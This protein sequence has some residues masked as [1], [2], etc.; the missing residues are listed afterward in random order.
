[1]KHYLPFIL[2][3][4]TVCFQCKKDDTLTDAEQTAALKNVTL[5]Y[6]S[7]NYVLGLPDGAPS[8][9]SFDQL[10]MEDS[11]KY[12]DP[13]N[14]SITYSSNFTADNSKNT[15]SD[16]KFEGMDLAVIMDTIKSGPI[17]SSVGSFEVKKMTKIPVAANST[18]NLKTHRKTGLYIFQQIVDGNDLATTFS[19]KLKYKIG[20]LQGSIP[21]PEIKQNIPTRASDNTRAFLSGLIQS[22]VFELKQ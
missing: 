19:P 8:G 2:L 7:A 17:N 15:S 12:C 13:E 3:I 18:I 11:A 4:T 10:K 20:T 22:G 1:M 14:Y 16:A 5:Q 9:K 6:D 21:V